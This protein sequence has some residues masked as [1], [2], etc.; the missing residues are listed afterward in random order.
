VLPIQEGGTAFD[1]GM[2]RAPDP[3]DA[4]HERQARHRI[5]ARG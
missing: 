1:R 4:R 2:G 3:G 5:P